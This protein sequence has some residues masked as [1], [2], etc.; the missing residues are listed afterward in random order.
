MA[1]RA[2]TAPLVTYDTLPLARE[3]HPGSRRLEDLAKHYGIETGQSHRALDDTKALA[4][5]FLKLEEDK[6]VRSRKTSLDG[7]LDKLGLA[8]ALTDKELR[9]DEAERILHRARI[10]SF[11]GRSN[12]LDAYRSEIELSSD[13][14]VIGIEEA[15]KRLGGATLMLAV[16][17]DK[18]AE[19]LYPMAM[20]RIRPLFEIFK[21]RDLTDQIRGFLERVA[22]SRMQGEEP[23]TTRVN[24]MTLHAT[25]GLEFSR[26]Y[27]VGTEDSSLPG[28][29]QNMSTSELE[30]A[31]RLLYVGMTRTKDR[32]ILTR[33]DERNEKPT[34]GHR[35][36]DEMSLVP[37]APD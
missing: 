5:L 8:L 28:D 33:V 15:I 7:L 19:Q 24:L 17:N 10:R 3:L 30:E 16:R 23:E 36:L 14:T 29:K 6:I 21:G 37:V 4:E 18:S 12:C 25:K 1:G 2:E 20:S 26:V 11:S 35:F 22:L 31:R 27:V 13:P 34:G 9:C 32:L